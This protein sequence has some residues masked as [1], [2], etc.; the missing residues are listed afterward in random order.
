MKAILLVTWI[1]SGQSP[2]SYQTIFDSM[3]AC[4]AAR[5][6]VIEEAFRLNTEW[7]QRAE[8][9]SRL[10]NEYHSKLVG[11]GWRPDVARSE[12]E[13]AYQVYLVPRPQPK[14]SAI[15]AAQ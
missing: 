11:R 13:R 8:E 4:Q 3:E 15:C 14:V 10:M 1:I 9:I 7:E 2:N 6:A 5:A 12:A